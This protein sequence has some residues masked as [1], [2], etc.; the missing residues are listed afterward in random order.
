MQ[1][2]LSNNGDVK[3]AFGNDYQAVYNHYVNYGI[4]ENRI[5]DRNAHVFG[6]FTTKK[7][8]TCTEVGNK[9]CSICGDE[10][11]IPAS[12]NETIPVIVPEEETV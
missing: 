12:E 6:K 5:A 4:K 1:H 9:K 7:E 2:Y 10:K 3:K 11:E 8:A